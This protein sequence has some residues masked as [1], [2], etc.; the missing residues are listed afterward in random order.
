M[1]DEITYAFQSFNIIAT[2]VWEYISYLISHFTEHVVTYASWDNSQ[3]M[4]ETGSHWWT[5]WRWRMAS[6]KMLMQ[7]MSVT[8]AIFVNLSVCHEWYP[9]NRSIVGGCLIDSQGPLYL[10]SLTLI[11][12]WISNHLPGKVARQ[13]IRWIFIIM[14]I[15]YR[16]RRNYVYIL[17]FECFDNGSLERLQAFKVG[18]ADA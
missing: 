9:M 13:L 15:L 3:S 12:A 10:H 17:R 11:P 4:L 1:W 6:Y 7:F 14:F 16:H 5:S 18:R 8:R 2:L